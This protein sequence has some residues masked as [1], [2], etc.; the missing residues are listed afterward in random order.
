M[1]RSLNYLVC[2]VALIVL[3]CSSILSKA[4]KEGDFEYAIDANSVTITKYAGQGGKVAVPASISGIPVTKLHSD[5]F[6]RSNGK[7]LTEVNIPASVTAIDAYQ[8]NGCA[9]LERVFLPWGIKS[10]GG[11]AFMGCTSL[12]TITIPDTVSVIH[13]SAFFDCGELTEVIVPPEVTFL[14]DFAFMG[15]KKLNV[16][17]FLGDAPTE[18][19][20]KDP[21]LVAPGKM[22]KRIGRDIFSGCSSNLTL[23]FMKGRKGFDAPD[24]QG[25]RKIEFD[26]HT[27]FVPWTAADGRILLARFTKLNSDSVVLQKED[28]TV[29]TLRFDRLSSASSNQAKHIGQTNQGSGD[30]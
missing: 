9:K 3:F 16:V 20:F 17:T 12:K 22:P 6:A 18:G 8:F 27:E 2:S 24:L 11:Y 1:K 14:G 13:V 30:N 28:K 15:C 21:D 29:H 4:E 5:A 10:I 26:P 19:Y 25:Y 23:R 7:D